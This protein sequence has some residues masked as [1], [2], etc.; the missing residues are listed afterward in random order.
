MFIA[1]SKTGIY[2]DGNTVVI[3]RMDINLYP[4][5]KFRKVFIVVE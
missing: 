3:S 5:K 1:K 4:A 2:R